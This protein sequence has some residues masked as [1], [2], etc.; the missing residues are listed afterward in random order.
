MGVGK[1]KGS[2]NMIERGR[3]WIWGMERRNM[4]ERRGRSGGD[5][6][7]KINHKDGA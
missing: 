1:G 2:E 4:M 7:A 6:I 5:N 3:G